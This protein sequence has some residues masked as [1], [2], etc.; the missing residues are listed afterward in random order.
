M[1]YRLI[2]LVFA[3]LMTGS[4]PVA[5]DDCEQQPNMA[6]VRAC[7]ANE[8]DQQLTSAY[9]DTLNFVKSKD[10]QAAKLLSNAQESWRKFAEDSCAYSV[11]A[12]ETEQMANDARLNCWATFVD[13]RIKIL[14]AYRQQFGQ[15]DG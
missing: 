15:A 12:R 10:P 1:S 7:A 11:A 3:V 2:A 13:A 4:M 5:A 8:A 14:K 6:A 9:N